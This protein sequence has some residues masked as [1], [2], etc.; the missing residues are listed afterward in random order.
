[1]AG[2]LDVLVEEAVP[3]A[4]GIIVRRSG[5]MREPPGVWLLSGREIRRAEPLQAAGGETESDMAEMSGTAG[6]FAGL[7][8]AHG[9]EPV[10]EHGVLRGEVLGL[11]VA[12]VIGGQLVVGVGR[13]DRNARAEMRPGED[14]GSALDEAVAAVRAWRRPEAQRHPA[15]TLARSRWLRSVVVARPELVG[16]SSLET[17]APPMPWFDLPEAGAAP[18]AGRLADGSPVVVVCSVG[19][20]LDL[21]PT[22]ADCR[23]IYGPLGNLVIAVPDGD[24]VPVNRR[25][26]AALARPAKVVT[27]P[28]GWEAALARP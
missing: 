3:G 11:E 8:V 14:L 27:V 19:I 10:L 21:V 24:D 13:H 1:G 4:A 20:D 22:A 5:E 16:A 17:V 7:L 28:K 6:E 23:L 18:C 26:A 2:S 15:N 12:R 25:L 9:V